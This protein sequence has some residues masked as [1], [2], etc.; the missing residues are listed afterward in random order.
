[1]PA[2]WSSSRCARIRWRS[3]LL[4][5]DGL[6]V[7]DDVPDVRILDLIR[8]RHHVQ[9]GG[10]AV[11][12]DGEDLAVARAVLPLLVG[13]VGRGRNEVVARPALRVAAVTARAVAAIELLPRPDR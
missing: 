8:E 12:D 13:E 6:D 9:L 7:V 10:H 2:S 5:R 1:R 11:L 4:L 3:D